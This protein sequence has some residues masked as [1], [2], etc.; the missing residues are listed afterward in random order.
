VGRGNP[1]NARALG[2]TLAAFGVASLVALDG[3]TGALA[4]LVI[5]AIL[6]LPIYSRVPVLGDEF[7]LQD[8]IDQQMRKGMDL[9]AELSVPVRPTKAA[10]G[11]WEISDGGPPAAWWDKTQEYVDQATALL[12]RRPALLKDFESGYNPH[13]HEVRANPWPEDLERRTTAEKM[14]ALA[15]AE[16]SAPKTIVEASLGGLTEARRRLPA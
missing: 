10:N 14:L 11:T 13:L 15:N 2:S 7:R 4:V 3:L 6:W 12:E 1:T 9:V 5:A 16:R 8:H